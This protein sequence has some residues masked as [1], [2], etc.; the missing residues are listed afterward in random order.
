MLY[1]TLT[2]GMWFTEEANFF[3]GWQV[4]KNGEVVQ[5]Y[6]I[7]PQSPSTEEYPIDADWQDAYEQWWETFTE[8]LAKGLDEAMQN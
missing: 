3:A 2:F 8:E 6:E 4:F 1:P 7:D 5:E